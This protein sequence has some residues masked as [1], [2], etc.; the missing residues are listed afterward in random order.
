MQ[1]PLDPAIAFA[2]LPGIDL[3]RAMIAGRITG[4]SIAD[5]MA[6]RLVEV[7]PGRVL[8]VGTPGRAHLNPLGQVHGGWALTLIDSACGCAAHTLL[9][10]G[11]GYASI[12][13]RCNFTRAIRPDHGEI[14]AE[15][16]VIVQGRQLI[17]TDATMTDA[18]GRI[19]AHGS[20]TIM[21]LGR[22][23]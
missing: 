17:T 14:R 5:G 3:L 19:V 21:V 10:P 15:G 6:F 13:T 1:H 18:D 9:D 11:V 22:R 23:G 8:F 12:E 4:P 20:S 7:D 2:T 16:R